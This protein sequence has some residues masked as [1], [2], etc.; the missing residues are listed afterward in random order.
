M[1]IFGVFIPYTRRDLLLGGGVIWIF[2]RVWN[3]SRSEALMNE[4]KKEWK[5]EAE[6]IEM[7]G[8]E[9]R[10]EPEWIEINET[11]TNRN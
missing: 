9:W 4:L 6:W 5:N 10:N 8:S 3:V 11:E 7:N 2:S 1:G